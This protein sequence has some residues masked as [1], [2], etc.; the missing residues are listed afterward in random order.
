MAKPTIA[1]L[2]AFK[3]RE[4]KI[5]KMRAQADALAKQQRELSAEWLPHVQKNGG[6]ARCL[7]VGPFTLLV[8]MKRKSVY[9][10]GEYIKLE[11]DVAADALIAAQ[12]EN[13]ILT[14]TKA[15]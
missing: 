14:I 6:Q 13:P 8:E 1:E 7:T 15:E 11:G 10:K 4:L 9:W 12:P 2:E 3:K 5:E